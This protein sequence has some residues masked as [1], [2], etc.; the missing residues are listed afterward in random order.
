MTQQAQAGK[1]ADSGF[2][3]EAWAEALAAFNAPFQTKLSRQ[4]NK[5]ILTALKGIYTAIKAM[6]DASGFGWDNQR[7][8]VLVH[9]SV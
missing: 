2:M 7:H 9:D 8:I 4:Q 5:S 3:K 6:L 1:R